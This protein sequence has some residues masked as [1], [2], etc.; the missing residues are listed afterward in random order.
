MSFASF[1]KLAHQLH[2]FMKQHDLSKAMMNGP[3]YH[4]VRVACA[5]HYFAGASPYDLAMTFAI[6][7]SE[8]FESMWDV[9]DAVNNHPD[10]ETRYPDSHDEQ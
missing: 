10:F 5:I 3:I 4:S 1:M 7:V 6:G 9:V 2:P 8:V